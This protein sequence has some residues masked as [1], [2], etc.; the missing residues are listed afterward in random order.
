[1]ARNTSMIKRGFS[2]DNANST[3]DLY[4]NGTE[5]ATFSTTTV[6]FP[7]TASVWNFGTSDSPLSYTA[8]TPCFTLYAT[9]AGTSSTNAEPFYVKSTL[10]GAGGYG[11]RSRFHTYSN[12]AS[13][14]N[15][16][17]LKAYMEY[18]S[19]GTNSGLSAAFCAELAM[20]NANTG[21]GGVYTVLELEYVAG[22]TSTTT[23]GSLTGNHA[24]FIRA[25]ASG[26]ADGDFD[27]N[28]YFMVVSG[29]TAGAAHLLSTTS[30]TLKCG[31]G[32]STTRYLVLSQAEDGLAL[33]NST[34]AQS[35]TAG[36]PPLN[37]YFTNAGTSGSTSA[38]PFYLKS[39]LTGAAQVGGR[40]RFHCYSNVASGG[41]VN[42]LKAYMEFGASGR[43]TGLASAFCA[44]IVM[45]ATN[46][47][48]SYCC[49]EAEMY[50]PENAV[51][52]STTSF[53]YMNVDG[54]STAKTS[55]N[56]NGYLFQLG[57]GVADTAGG[58]FDV[59]NADDIDA[60]AALKIKVANTDYFIPISTTSAFNA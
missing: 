28:G 2:W 59:V 41:W 53:I 1:M 6:N 17:A 49:L 18:G 36:T 20:P 46:A 8:G 48:G 38:E 39:T 15:V 34:T 52:G 51:I 25:T 43:T 60:T 54:N 11:G 30:Q 22:G 19:S 9:N 5:V 7:N 21:S 50:T 10:T 4:V 29:L 40:A 56:T 26:D 32:T 31:I 12:V 45:P 42:A 23:A 55:F 13:G 57:S 58:L 24:Q 37:F 35:Y 14:S 33:G 44:E 3:L 16:M 27:D 47:A